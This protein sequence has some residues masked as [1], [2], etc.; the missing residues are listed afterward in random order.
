M[1]LDPSSAAVIAQQYLATND[2]LQS[3]GWGIGGYVY[4]SPDSRTAVKIHR[5]VDGYSREL[6]VY[7][8]L[9]QLRISQVVGL[10]LP[11]LRGSRDD[12]RAIEMDFVTPPFLVDFAGAQLTAPDFE[13]DVWD[14][15]HTQ[16]GEMFGEDAP[17][18]YAVYDALAREGIYYLD[19]RPSNLKL[20]GLA[21][22]TS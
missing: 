15:W 3:L 17:L 21:G 18:V 10:T 19:F 12:L 1:S 9:Q 13:T 22:R 20:E 6:A 4:L 8:H 11:K 7:R 16:I 2:R 5:Y 14:H